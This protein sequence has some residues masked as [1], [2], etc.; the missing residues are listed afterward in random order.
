MLG[1]PPLATSPV[2]GPHATQPQRGAH[3]FSAAHP[4]CTYN[5]RS[6]AP[7]RC[8]EYLPA[9]DAAARP[10]PPQHAQRTTPPATGPM[11]GMPEDNIAHLHP[12]PPATSSQRH[13]FKWSPTR[14]DL[15]KPP[16]GGLSAAGP[17]GAMRAPP[18][19][20]Y[21]TD[22]ASA[23]TTL[24]PMQRLAPEASVR[25]RAPA[26]AHGAPATD[27]HAARCM[28]RGLHRAQAQP[29]DVKSETAR[30]H[31]SHLVAVAEECPGTAESNYEDSTAGGRL[32][33]MH[34]C[35]VVFTEACM[36]GGR[37]AGQP[38]TKSNL[39]QILHHLAQR[40]ARPQDAESPAERAVH[41]TQHAPRGT[42]RPRP[43][44]GVAAGAPLGR[45]V[46]AVH[47]VHDEDAVSFRRPSTAE[48]V[49]GVDAAEHDP[50][51]GEVSRRLLPCSHACTP[52]RAKLCLPPRKR[53]AA[54]AVD[55]P[56]LHRD[57]PPVRFLP[58]CVLSDRKS[59]V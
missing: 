26:A 58:A 9:Q 48:A 38:G 11:H 20:G 1:E 34:A 16:R 49:S 51:A 57:P 40:A 23:S 4:A 6:A 27:G 24:P 25:A 35:G 15:A 29:L 33:C 30:D 37:A 36:H 14:P 47:A 39:L 3:A 5:S 52:R 32:P 2:A 7:V 17:P 41:S 59:V 12:P 42:P 28:L 44:W 18:C 54:E 56:P 31:P 43:A 45:A 10:R 22:T 8:A 53:S 19:L 13:S 50:Y 46:R 21:S 55:Q